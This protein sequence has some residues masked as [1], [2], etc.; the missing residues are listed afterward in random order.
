MEASVMARG[1]ESLGV[2]RE[3]T[4]P[5]MLSMTTAE[6]AVFCQELM[7]HEGFR[8][9]L[10]VTCCFHL[11]R[12]LDCFRAVGVEVQGL[13]APSPPLPWRAA[14]RRRVH[15]A[16]ALW[17]DRSYLRKICADRARGFHPFTGLQA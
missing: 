5:E 1:L 9:A 11:P 2:P 10:V 6:N 13:A 15:E 8:K 14:A 3:R 12:A 7:L 16:S 17:I 4:F